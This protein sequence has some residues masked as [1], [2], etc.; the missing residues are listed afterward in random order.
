MMCGTIAFS[1]WQ[2]A[3]RNCA[4]E[5]NKIKERGIQ[6]RGDGRERTSTDQPVRLRKIERMKSL[7]LT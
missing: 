6:S 3:A 7:M 1:P 5:T 4:A 2:N